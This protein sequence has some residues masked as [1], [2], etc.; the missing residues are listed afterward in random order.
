M[1]VLELKKICI[2]NL[3]R[4]WLKLGWNSHKDIDPSFVIATG[5]MG[6]PLAFANVKSDINKLCPFAL[7]AKY[8]SRIYSTISFS[9]L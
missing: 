4:M 8:I 9:T 2:E 6:G 1:E 5:G 7:E 3:N